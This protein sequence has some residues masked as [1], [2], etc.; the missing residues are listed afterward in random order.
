MIICYFLSLQF[1]DIN[2]ISPQLR[3]LITKYVNNNLHSSGLNFSV[4]NCTSYPLS[5]DRQNYSRVDYLFKNQFLNH[6]N[7]IL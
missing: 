6:K 2:S 5:V 7:Y 4:C 3:H 1:F